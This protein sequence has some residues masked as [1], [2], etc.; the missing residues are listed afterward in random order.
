MKRGLVS[1]R[2]GWALALFAVLDLACLGL[3]MLFDP[4]AD[5]ANFGI[6]LILYDPAAKRGNAR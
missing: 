3:G 5:L 4:A 1:L 2:I 6:P